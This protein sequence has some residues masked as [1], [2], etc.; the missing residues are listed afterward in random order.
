MVRRSGLKLLSKLVLAAITLWALLV[1]ASCTC[2]GG[3]ATASLIPSP[4]EAK[5]GEQFEVQ[6]KI[7][8]GNQGVSAVEIHLVFDAKAMQVMDI[9]SG[10]LLGERPLPGILEID[11]EAGIL[12]YSLA[13]IGETTPPTPAA[14]F[15]T[16]TFLI[17][18]SAKAGD[19]ELSCTGVGLANENFEDIPSIKVKRAS[20]KVRT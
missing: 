12:S 17:L 13:R 19:Y 3:G 4:E 18:E 7:E 10:E 6:V 9:R 1:T 16:I 11:N 8:P 14:T 15:A 5:P 20:V 2:V